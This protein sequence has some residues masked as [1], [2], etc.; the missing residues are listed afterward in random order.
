M[1]QLVAGVEARRQIAQ[2]GLTPKLFDKWIA[3][4]GGPKWLPLAA[5]DR[6]LSQ[7]FL[8]ST[9]PLT[10]MGTSSGAWRCAALCHPQVEAAHQR[11][12]YHYIHQRYDA[13][14]SQQEVAQQCRALLEAAFEPQS[15]AALVGH[16]HRRLNLIVCR[17]PFARG[18]KA[19]MLTAAGLTALV[20]LLSRR[21]ISL[22]WQRW[23]LHSGEAGPFT[24]MEDLPTYCAPLSGDSLI[25]ALLASGSIPMVLPGETA[26]PGVSSGRYFDGGITDYHLDLPALSQGG[27]TLYPHFYPSVTPGWFDKA[28][29]W[30]RASANL[31]KVVIL[32]P[33]A[34]FVAQ[35]PGGKLPD[36]TDFKRLPTEQRIQAWERASA[37]GELLVEAF[38]RLR[39]DPMRHLVVG[40]TD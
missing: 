38:E 36:R 4:S 1:L 24:R 39:E 13:P 9:Q 7:H 19:S 40:K 26:L 33:T 12:Q 22:L 27:L 29:P 3:A 35:L 5:L 15:R 8:S 10:L 28:L 2:Q 21:A 14:P 11:L 37:H 17:G 18:D 31:S 32:A 25:P 23:V 16:P 6:H 30:R 34:E 20:N